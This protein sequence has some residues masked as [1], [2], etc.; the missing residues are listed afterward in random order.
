MFE[1]ITELLS[2]IPLIGWLL[3]DIVGFADLIIA[4][5]VGTITFFLVVA[6]A[7][8]RYRPMVGYTVLA[9]VFAIIIV[10]VV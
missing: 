3:S 4:L 7:W 5:I 1:P 6:L 2:W 9:L 8:I 10:V